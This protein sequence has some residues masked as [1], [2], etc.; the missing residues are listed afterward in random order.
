MVG[1]NRLEIRALTVLFNRKW[2]PLAVQIVFLVVFA[3]LVI[4][5]LGVNTGDM[6]FAR[7]LRNTNL[8]N[9]LVWSYWWPAVIAGAVLFGRLWCTVC[10]I[11]LV[12]SL[13]SMVGLKRKVPGW[14]RNGWLITL[15]YLLILLVGIHTLA[16]HR[17]PLRMALYMLLLFALA[18]AFGLVFEKRAFCNHLCPVGPILGIYGLCSPFEVRVRNRETCRNCCSR[19][20]VSADN[21]YRL[22]GRSC[23]SELYPAALKHNRDCILCG[24]CFNSC[25]FD[26]MGVFLRRPFKDIF[27]KI[28]LSGAQAF[29]LYILSG[30][31]LYEILSEWQVTKDILIWLPDRLEAALGIADPYWAGF[32]AAQVIFLVYPLLWWVVPAVMNKLLYPGTGVREYFKAIAIYFV[33]ILAGAHVLKAVLKTTSRIPYIKLSLRDPAGINTARAIIS[34]AHILD[35]TVVTALQPYISI[36]AFLSLSGVII[37]SLASLRKNYGSRRG[38]STIFPSI[39]ILLYGLLFLTALYFWRL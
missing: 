17:V 11:E 10:P 37:V 36:F 38:H 7:I 12:T 3:L 32:T 16:I 22:T 29:L 24:Q 31:V 18:V 13:M 26:N 28:S 14:M 23:T 6:K 35:K 8:S 20:C 25:S 1:N 33:P 19:D 9:L 15:F 34:G 27:G 39:G 5:G 30:F 2:F 4:G 21:Y